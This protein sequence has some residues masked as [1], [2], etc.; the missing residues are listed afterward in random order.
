MGHKHGLVK[1]RKQNEAGEW[2]ED[3]GLLNEDDGAMEFDKLV[4]VSPDGSKRMILTLNNDGVVLLTDADNH[5]FRMSVLGI[6][7]QMGTVVFDGAKS[8]RVNF[9]RSF[10]KKPAVMLTL[11]DEGNIPA[12][13]TWVGKTGFTIRFKNNYTGEVQWQGL[14]D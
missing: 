1:M 11:G 2:Y 3:H 7:V 14:E 8:M 10:A 9:A 12:Y 6:N 13:R 5:V 4:L